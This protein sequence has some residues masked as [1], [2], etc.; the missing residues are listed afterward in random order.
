MASI[1]DSVPISGGHSWTIVSKLGHILT[2]AEQTYGPRDKDYTILGVELTSNPVPTYWYPGDSKHILIQITAEC[3]NNMDKAV[4]QVAHEAVHCLFPPGGNI[5]VSVLEEGIACH[6][7]LEYCK[8]NGHGNYL[9][10]NDP[11]YE[12]ALTQYKK[13]L[14]IDSGII[15]NLRRIQPTV[16]LVTKKDLLSVNS[17][18]PDTLIDEL[19]KKF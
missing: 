7:Q 10:L 1:F 6:F 13:L 9:K 12:D 8:N 17:T 19:I 5:R 4:F 11:R 3:M 16:S 2:I 15:K 18:I 14:A